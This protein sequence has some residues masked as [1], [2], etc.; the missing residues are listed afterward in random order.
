MSDE[1][2]ELTMEEYRQLH[3]E[4]LQNRGFIF[5]RVLALAAIV[6]LA[7]GVSSLPQ[8]SQVLAAVL[9]SVVICLILLSIW[10]T[11]GRLAAQKGE[12]TRATLLSLGLR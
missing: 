6:V 5:E 2:T 9:F 4:R 8:V 10:F 7:T 11:R 12:F 3:A 1:M